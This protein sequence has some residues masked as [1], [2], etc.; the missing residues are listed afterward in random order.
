MAIIHMKSF[1]RPF[2]LGLGIICSTCFFL[3]AALSQVLHELIIPAL[4]LS[5]A[6]L[7]SAGGALVAL[8]RT[9]S[10]CPG[11][12]KVDCEADPL[13][14]RPEGGVNWCDL[15]SVPMATVRQH[16]P[17]CQMCFSKRSHHNPMLGCCIGHGNQGSFTALALLVAAHG[18]AG[19]C[20]FWLN[21]AT[22]LSQTGTLSIEH[23]ALLLCCVGAPALAEF[24]FGFSVCVSIQFQEPLLLQY[25]VQW[26]ILVAIVRFLSDADHAAPVVLG[27]RNSDLW[28]RKVSDPVY[29][30]P[31]SV[32]S[33]AEEAQPCSE[34]ARSVPGQICVVPTPIRA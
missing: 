26:P 20:A 25:V 18:F 19:G 14:S 32:E 10:T 13:L 22:R 6:I 29:A 3:G 4:F 28:S 16:C 34:E 30:V 27:G 21:G 11:V 15:C 23:V 12:F 1:L 31:E 17:T 2:F 7:V 5:M 9:R 24:I 33:C 8:R